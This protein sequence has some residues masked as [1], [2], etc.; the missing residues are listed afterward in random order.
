MNLKKS[1]SQLRKSSYR[2]LTERVLERRRV[3][4][5]LKDSSYRENRG[6]RVVDRI[7]KVEQR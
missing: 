5:R 2:G 3:L 1:V 6:N 4:E 7:D